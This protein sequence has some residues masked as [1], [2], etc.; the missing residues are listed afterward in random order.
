MNQIFYNLYLLN[1]VVVFQQ[2]YITG[3]IP[4]NSHMVQVQ[5]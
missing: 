1:K 3:Y 2:D 5:F 4:E